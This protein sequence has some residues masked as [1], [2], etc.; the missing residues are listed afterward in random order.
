MPAD[1]AWPD[2]AS[3]AAF[4]AWLEGVPSRAAVDRYLPDRRTAGA[5]SRSVIGRV[6]RQLVAF[7]TGRA[8]ADLA[9]T[10]SAASPSGR[11]LAKAAAA[12]IET[13][14]GMPPPQ[15]LIGD[16][17]E[18]WL[19][20]RLV[21][22]L[23][24]V[25]IRTLA[26]LTL[27]VP[28][29]RRWWTGIAG[30]GPSGAHSIEAFFARH[31]ALTERARALVAVN[32]TQDLIPWER[33]V[34]P[35]DVDG[36]RGTFRAP[37]ASC[38]LDASNDYQAVNAWL[39]LHESAA[40]QRAYRKEAERLILWAIVERGRALSSM[41][42][43]DAVAY[44]A[45]LRRPS[46]RARWVG[47]PRPRSTPEWR[48][49]TGDL[50]ARSTAYALSVLNAMYRW[51]IEQRYALANP[52]AGV[53]VRGGRPEQLDTSHA[54]TEHEWKLVRVVAEGLEW[55]YG[56]SEPAA[57]RLRFMMDFA[58]ATG[59]RISELVVAR[60]GTIDSDAHGDTWIRVV[61]KGHKAGKVVL[62]PLARAALD[63]YLAQRGLPVT[64]SK[65]RPSTS[66]IG[67]LG[68][69]GSRI[70]SWRMWRVLKR[71]F[72]TVADVVEEGSPALA[73]KLRRAT[74][75]WTRHTHATHLLEGGAELTTV[76]DN[77]RH[78]SLATTS[79]YL[80]T[81]DARRAKQ[82]ADRFAAPRS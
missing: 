2:E 31:P 4:R 42:T 73:E 23:H 11:K 68:E 41:T 45:F 17:V 25:G 57:Q 9:A 37:R 6:K 12:A 43:E 55:S 29:H 81:D 51:L 76:R 69:D 61:G 30:L 78:A 26:E 7:A 79:M 3:L 14:R 36:S 40:T 38:A 24:A 54:F 20:V 10:L 34:V 22:A 75:H 44:R 35:E 32:Q 53:K 72:A 60:L 82:V 33:L 39:S 66:L 71:F 49:F 18:R 21:G 27:R 13:L 28:R 52:F 46:P 77:L 1:P 15:P 63:R 62:P 16:A 5:S 47:P 8:Q 80:H 59:L 64:P 58:Y 19:P 74:P 67:R 48:P 70:S 56:W 50:S 65:W